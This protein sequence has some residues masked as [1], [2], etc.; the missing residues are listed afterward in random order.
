MLFA[1]TEYGT[2]NEVS[3]NGNIYSYGILLLEMFTGKRPTDNMFK[4]SLNLRDFVNGVSL[5]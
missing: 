1:I 4:D 2:V 5:K 3:T